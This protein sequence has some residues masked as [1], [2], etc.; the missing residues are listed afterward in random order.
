MTEKGSLRK[1]E[2][3]EVNDQ[4]QNSGTRHFES[5]VLFQILITYT[6]FYSESVLKQFEDT[7]RKH[8]LHCRETKVEFY[9][10]AISSLS[11]ALTDDGHLAPVY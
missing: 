7:G 11:C 1:K 2:E 4:Q 10:S 9:S 6:V 8:T 5:K 3:G